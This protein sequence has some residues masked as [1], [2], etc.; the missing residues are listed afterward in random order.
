MENICKMFVDF[1][2]FVFGIWYDQSL[3]VSW[4]LRRHSVEI[5]LVIYRTT[6]TRKTEKNS[7]KKL[8]GLEEP[9]LKNE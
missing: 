5:V 2:K 3:D 4:S 8:Y 1:R 7:W 9:L 6:T